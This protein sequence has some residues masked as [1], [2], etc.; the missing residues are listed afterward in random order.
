MDD[1][2]LTDRRSMVIRVPEGG[3]V[4][5]CSC[6][7]KPQRAGALGWIVP[8]VVLVLVPKCPLCLVAYAATV[9]V[10][11]SFSTAAAMRAA[12]VITCV[13]VLAIHLARAAHRK[14]ARARLARTAAPRE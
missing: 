7:P 6:K 13:A 4:V 12:A 3:C 9:G 5:A 10:A 8:V 1:V 11:L 14:G 2:W